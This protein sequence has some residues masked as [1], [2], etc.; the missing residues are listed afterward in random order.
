MEE[1]AKIINLGD[2]TTLFR[3]DLPGHPEEQSGVLC[4]LSLE[5]V[6]EYDQNDFRSVRVYTSRNHEPVIPK[7]EQ[8]SVYISMGTAYVL[9]LL[10]NR[11]GG[12]ETNKLEDKLL[13]G[14]PDFLLGYDVNSKI[15]KPSSRACI[16]EYDLIS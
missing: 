2:H 16:A 14:C 11:V 6:K 7:K 10:D 1:K 3:R 4:G 8:F 12:R 9:S 15:R 5:F 13:E